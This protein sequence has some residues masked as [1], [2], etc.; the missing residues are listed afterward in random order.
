MGGFSGDTEVAKGATHEQCKAISTM[1]GKV[2][3]TPTENKQGEDT[4]A[5][6]KVAV[7]P[8][9]FAQAETPAMI[10][11]DH[12]IPFE[13]EEAET[14]TATPQTRQ[15]RKDTLEEPRPPPPFPQRLK[16]QKQEYQY[17]KFFDILK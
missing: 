8:D 3:K 11:E 13:P 4:V 2:L 9:N 5:R 17:K 7:V 14:A 12:N 6:S 15:P 1:S 16:N 10:E